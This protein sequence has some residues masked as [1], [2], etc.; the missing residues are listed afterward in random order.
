MGYEARN[1]AVAKGRYS[2]IKPES[3]RLRERE[4]L[5]YTSLPSAK[6]K[7]VGFGFLRDLCRCAI[8]MKNGR[9]W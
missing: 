1:R 5:Q 3:K 9:V 2:H 4:S 8:G 7:N 6:V